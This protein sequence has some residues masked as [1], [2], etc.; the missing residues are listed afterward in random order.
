[1]IGTLHKT[2]DIWEVWFEPDDSKIDKYPVHPDSQT[3]MDGY[4]LYEGKEVEFRFLK[5]F[6][7]DKT[8]W[9]AKILEDEKI[10]NWD[11]IYESY[12]GTSDLID[13]FEWLKTN[14]HT[15]NKR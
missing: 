9:Y 2:D 11:D 14:Y 10:F 15:P 8:I 7:W 12:K 4:N 1:M 13:F 3:W 6:N 5:I